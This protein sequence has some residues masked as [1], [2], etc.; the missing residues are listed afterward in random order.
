MPNMKATGAEWLEERLPPVEAFKLRGEPDFYG[1][2]CLVAAALGRRE[3]PRSYAYWTHGWA[4]Q[5][6]VHP[7]QLARGDPRDRH[8][9]GAEKHARLLHGFGFKRAEAVG[10]PFA[11]V[12]DGD[13]PRRSG[14]LLVMPAHSLPY[15]E[16][17]WDER[18]YVDRIAPLRKQFACVIACVSKSC[19][20]KGMWPA[21]FERRGIPW[22]MGADIE[23]R[24]ALVRMSRIFRSFEYMTTNFIGSQ[25][26]YAAYSGCKVSV[27]GPYATYR[28]EDFRDDPWYSRY[29][30]LLKLNM[31]A[32][33]EK[34]AK[35]R[36]PELFCGP[37]DAVERTEWG[38]EMVGARYRRTPREIAR[39][40]GW[41][42]MR[43]LRERARHLL[44]RVDRLVR[45][46]L[47]KG[48]G[49]RSAQAR[50]AQLLRAY[51]TRC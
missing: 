4:S 20:E 21:E 49:E 15:T 31:Q 7:R 8:L 34:S 45:R 9:V 33:G 13:V 30:D 24:N 1:A 51:A 27:Y 6:I 48:Q 36:F 18:E 12:E 10:L 42:P 5:P 3:P 43:Q 35:E 11:Y 22:V 37:A 19:V 26:A 38:R 16:H 29:P 40:L 28:P 17:E 25:V 47:L 39:L 2:S 44:G 41:S 50:Y 32:L 46:A 23:D 14:S